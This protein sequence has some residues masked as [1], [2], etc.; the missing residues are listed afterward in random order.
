MNKKIFN[1]NTAKA[2]KLALDL[3]ANKQITRK[4]CRLVLEADYTDDNYVKCLT[5]L[6]EEV[7]RVK[8]YYHSF[9]RINACDTFIDEWLKKY[10]EV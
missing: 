7:L 1:K 10:K 2:K 3:F 4:M 9:D 5:M 6:M 8:G